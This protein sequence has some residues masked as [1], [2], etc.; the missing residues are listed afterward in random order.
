MRRW[1]G[2]PGGRCTRASVDPVAGGRYRLDSELADGSAVIIS[3]CF[4]LV[5]PPRRL[6][7]TWQVEPGPGHSELVTVTFTAVAGG[8][9]VTV[10]HTAIRDEPTRDEHAAGWAA[11]LDR[12]AAYAEPTGRYAGS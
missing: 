2:P 8:T 4:T 11:C 6:T 9:E 10:E 1:W 7:Y 3:G 5:E 12:L